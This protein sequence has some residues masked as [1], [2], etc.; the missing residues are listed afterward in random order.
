[1]TVLSKDSHKILLGEQLRGTFCSPRQGGE[2]RPGTNP[3]DKGGGRARWGAAVVLLQPSSALP[4]RCLPRKEASN[5]RARGTRAAD[6][7]PP[8][9]NR[10][11][12][13]QRGACLE[14]IRERMRRA[15]CRAQGKPGRRRWKRLCVA[16]A[17]LPRLNSRRPLWEAS[18]MEFRGTLFQAIVV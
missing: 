4:F 13:A 6:S 5:P 18:P 12:I 8:F 7:F 11:E 16:W 10:R 9:L 1:M 2:F 15:A 17:R 14:E 3:G